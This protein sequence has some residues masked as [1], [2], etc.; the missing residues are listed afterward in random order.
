MGTITTEVLE[1]ILK[2]RDRELIERLERLE[3]MMRELLNVG[4]QHEEE[5]KKIECE[6][7]GKR[8]KNKKALRNHMRKHEREEKKEEE[9]EETVA[10]DEAEEESAA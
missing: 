2:H 1:V 6:I 4:A 8:F 9:E 3:S 10:D 5:E 7:C